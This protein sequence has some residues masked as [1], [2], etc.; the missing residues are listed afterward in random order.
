MVSPVRPALVPAGSGGGGGKSVGCVRVDPGLPGIG[1]SHVVSA[2][3]RSGR[4][5]AVDLSAAGPGAVGRSCKCRALV[6][7]MVRGSG[8][9]GFAC[10][11]R[12]EIGG[13]FG[14][15]GENARHGHHAMV[16]RGRVGSDSATAEPL[17]IGHCRPLVR[18]T[19]ESH[20]AQCAGKAAIGRPVGVGCFCVATGGR[21]QS[22]TKRCARAILPFTWTWRG[23]LPTIRSGR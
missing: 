14:G 22:A 23:A 21:R 11:P 6:S 3:I 5:T 19:V 10:T 1:R 9:S 4:G 18:G 7:E 13:G 2:S 20:L 8:G 16:V 12:P 15:I 17:G